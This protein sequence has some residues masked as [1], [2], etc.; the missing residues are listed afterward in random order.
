MV[1]HG[2]IE[3]AQEVTS[4]AG[5]VTALPSRVDREAAERFAAYV[6]LHAFSERL[7]AR[8]VANRIFNVPRDQWAIR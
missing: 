2:G 1:A 7:S 6:E 8:N 4:E 3:Q 5:Q